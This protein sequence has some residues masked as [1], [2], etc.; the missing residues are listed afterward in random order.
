[1]Q[2]GRVVKAFL[3]ASTSTQLR[4]E[5]KASRMTTD[6][7]VQSAV[8]GRAGLIERAYVSPG[9]IQEEDPADGDGEEVAVRHDV[10]CLFR[11]NSPWLLRSR[12]LNKAPLSVQG[13]AFKLIFQ[14]W[15]HIT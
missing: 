3:E 8:G 5:T 13:R 10:C 7:D 4:L 11:S 9:L 12:G 14:P 15:F 2:N 1:M 6:P